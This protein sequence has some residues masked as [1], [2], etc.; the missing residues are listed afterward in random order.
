MS[1]VAECH[2]GQGVEQAVCEA[3][4]RALESDLGHAADVAETI[5]FRVRIVLQKFDLHGNAAR[6][7]PSYLRGQQSVVCSGRRPQHLPDLTLLPIVT[8]DQSHSGGIARLNPFKF[9][10][11]KVHHDKSMCTIR[12]IKNGLT[13]RHR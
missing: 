7:R 4:T 6:Y 8:S 5:A 2:P 9:A 1:S 12:K 13:F 10:L 3:K 11:W